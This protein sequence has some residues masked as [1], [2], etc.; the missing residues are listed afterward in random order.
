MPILQ[1]ILDQKH[2]FSKDKAKEFQF[3]ILKSRLDFTEGYNEAMREVRSIAHLSFNKGVEFCLDPIVQMAD[4]EVFSDWFDR[5]F[6]N[7]NH[8]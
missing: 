1:E 6:K 5:R 7:I 2:P 4:Y 3:H 8:V